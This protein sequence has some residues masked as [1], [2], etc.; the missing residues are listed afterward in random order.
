MTQN[1]IDQLER[2]WRSVKGIENK[3]L[4]FKNERQDDPALGCNSKA[5]DLVA[6]T[7]QKTYRVRI[8]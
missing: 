6:K 5:D 1:N 3:K 2:N 4:E 8:D 7:T